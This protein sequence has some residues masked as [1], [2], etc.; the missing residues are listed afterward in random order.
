MCWPAAKA[1]R[2]ITCPWKPSR[3]A[4]C[5]TGRCL[6]W[7]ASTATSWRCRGCWARMVC[8]CAYSSTGRVRAARHSAVFERLFGVAKERD[9]G[10]REDLRVEAERPVGDVVVVP[11][12]A[13]REGG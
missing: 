4:F 1:R 2:A 11:L 3:A 6:R 12:D 5:A 9:E 10:E 8:A 7:T 13:L